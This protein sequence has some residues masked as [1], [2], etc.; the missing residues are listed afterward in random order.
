MREGNYIDAM[1]L[2][3]RRPLIDLGGFDEDIRMTGW[4]DYDLWCRCAS[5]GLRG[6]LVPQILTRYRRTEHSLLALAGID[7]Q[8]AWSM[9]VARYREVL[10]GAPIPWHMRS[11]HTDAS[12]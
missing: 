5:R 12:W 1:A 4:E 11:L 3:R 6:I 9:L 8:V 2:F 10:G 7:H